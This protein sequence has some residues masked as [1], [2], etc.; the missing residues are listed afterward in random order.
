MSSQDLTH[1]NVFGNPLIPCCYEPLTGF[2]RDGYC[3]T[4]EMDRGTHV[5]C[6]VMTKEFLDY[7]KNCGNNLCTPIPLYNFPGLQAG[8]K[9][10]LCISRW[11][12][13]EKAGFAP[14]IVLEATDESTL[15]YIN[16]D[17]L[18]KYAK[19]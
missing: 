9:W 8:D 5:V 1:K 7:T 17:T 3:R 14:L 6:A 18:L 12:E 13:A 2:F 19:K 11:I 4:D 15:D 16:M 10:C